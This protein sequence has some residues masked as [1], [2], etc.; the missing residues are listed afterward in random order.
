MTEI[1]AESPQNE[2]SIESDGIRETIDFSWSISDLRRRAKS[3]RTF[4]SAIAAILVTLVL[5][6]VTVV[7]QQYSGGE[8][9]GGF[10]N[11]LQKMETSTDYRPNQ[12]FLL[13]V[14]NILS[15]LFPSPLSG[16]AYKMDT[17]KDAPSVHFTVEDR[18]NQL[19]AVD[20][21]VGFYE[22]SEKAQAMN[23]ATPQ[24]DALSP[25][26][27]TLAFSAGAVVIAILLIQIMVTFMR[28][29]AQLAE[30]YDAQALALEASNGNAEI[31]IKFAEHF[32]P[33]SITFGK[34]PVTLYEKSLDT[35]AELARS[36]LKS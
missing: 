34:M 7:F 21:L 25:I 17:G 15:N 20:A 9:F 30:L 28:Y 19:K 3:A 4:R 5:V 2:K 23:K 14:D 1:A 10:R 27:S 18:T 13:R 31:A 16:I 32:S 29:Y 35:I 33:N 6:G 8:R 22:R 12:V 26:I 11:L 36:K 24:S